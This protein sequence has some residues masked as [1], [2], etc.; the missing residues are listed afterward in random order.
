[1]PTFVLEQMGILQNKRILS[2]QI[3]QVILVWTGISGII[4]LKSYLASPLAQ[5]GLIS[6]QEELIAWLVSLLYVPIVVFLVNRGTKSNRWMLSLGAILLLAGIGSVLWSQISTTEV[7]VPLTIEG[8]SDAVF[9]DNQ[10]VEQEA[11]FFRSKTI[12]MFSSILIISCIAFIVRFVQL[13]R[14]RERNEIKLE[15]LLAESN[16]KL[17]KSQMHPHFIFNTLNTVS[18]LMETDIDHAQQLLE[19]LSLLLRSS[20]R[21]SNKQ[22]IPLQEELGFLRRYFEIEQARFRHKLKLVQKV[23]SACE[24]AAIPH[25]ILQPLAENA[26]KHGFRGLD[27]PGVLSISIQRS[28]E[29]IHILLEDNGH[30]LKFPIKKGIGLELVERRLESL[31]GDQAMLNMER[32]KEGGTAA[33]MQLP[34]HQYQEISFPKNEP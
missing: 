6:L 9:F 28:G 33:A 15:G 25:M 13:S 18:G 3:Y 1:M 26:V 32:G 21:Q 7:V 31:Y 27:R 11:H 34:Y 22:L 17:L 5:L 8:E 19:D 16:L 14:Q 23:D 20:L 12:D 30:G 10:W 2:I 24:D 29:Q 4:L